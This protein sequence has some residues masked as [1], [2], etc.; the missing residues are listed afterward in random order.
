M[1]NM[2]IIAQ[3]APFTHCFAYSLGKRFLHTIRTAQFK[4]IQ[5]DQERGYTD[6]L[7][8]Y[9]LVID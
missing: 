9:F 7:N 4:P 1:K 5:I 6:L 2:N 8:L 3:K